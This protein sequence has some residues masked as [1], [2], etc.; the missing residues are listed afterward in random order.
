MKSQKSMSRLD[1]VQKDYGKSEEWVQVK[2]T[3]DKLERYL[4]R[5]DTQ[6]KI[7]DANIPGASSG[8]I[9]AVFRDFAERRLGFTNEAEGL[10]KKYQNSGLRP[11]YFKKIGED[12]GII[13]EVERGKTNINNMDFLDFWKCHICVH[14]H[15]LFLMVPVELRQNSTGR[16]SKPFDVTSKHMTPFFEEGNYTNVRGLVLFGY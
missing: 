16:S 1:L 2:Q 13:L 11:D 5:V 14:A 8:Q 10:F 7:R 9:Q 15:Y 12:S 6:I 3:A 4:D